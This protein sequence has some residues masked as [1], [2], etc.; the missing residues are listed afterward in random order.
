MSGAKRPGPKCQGVKD[1][2]P[3]SQ[4]VKRPGPKKNWTHYYHQNIYES[5]QSKGLEMMRCSNTVPK[6]GTHDVTRYTALSIVYR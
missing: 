6:S 3:K 5:D 2:G 4:G 1:P